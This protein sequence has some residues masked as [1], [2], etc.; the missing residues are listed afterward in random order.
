MNFH[1]ACRKYKHVLF[2]F[3]TDNL[4]FSFIFFSLFLSPPLFFIMYLNA[5]TKKL[6]V[7]QQLSNTTLLT[8]VSA[9]S[10]KSS[11]I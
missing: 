7:P 2:F 8:F 9:K 3:N 10:L 6:P 11:A 5:D 1:I 4:I